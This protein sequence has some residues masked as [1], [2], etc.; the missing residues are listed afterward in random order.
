MDD[1]KKVYT[2]D[3]VKVEKDTSHKAYE[4]SSKQ[5]NH[6]DLDQVQLNTQNL[7]ISVS[8]RSL[9]KI[10]GVVFSKEK[11]VL[12][13][14]TEIFL[15]FGDKSNHSVAKVISDHNG[16]FEFE[17]LPPGFYTLV[18]YFNQLE[19]IFQYITVNIGQSIFQLLPIT[20]A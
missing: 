20:Q 3:S 8:D 12:L 11:K 4:Q 19:Y 9:G 7:H 14:N 18:T 10:M 17:D 6:Q 1:D 15:F 5:L 16:Y 13:Y 2:E